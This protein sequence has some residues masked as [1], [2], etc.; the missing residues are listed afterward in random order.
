MPQSMSEQEVKDLIVKIIGEND[1][2]SMGIVMKALQVKIKGK[3]DGKRASE[4][5]RETL[6]S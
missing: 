3:F 2:P 5:V 4:L 1:N 6:K